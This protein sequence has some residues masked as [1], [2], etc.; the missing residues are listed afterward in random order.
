MSAPAP[1]PPSAPGAATSDAPRLRGFRMATPDV[2]A[3]MGHLRGVGWE[4]EY[5]Q[6]S[7]GRFAAALDG[8]S[9]PRV[10]VMTHRHELSFAGAG[11]IPRGTYA[12]GMLV[13]GD[14]AMSVN[15][16]SIGTDAVTIRYPYE[17]IDFKFPPAAMFVTV[18]AAANRID[19]MA[20]AVLGQQLSHVLRRGQ[21]L[22]S[23]NA[24]VVALARDLAEMPASAAWLALVDP[25]RYDQA[26]MD[27]LLQAVRLPEPIRGWSAR[28]RIVRKAEDLICSSDDPPTT[29]S[30]LCVALAVPL[31]TLEDA[32]QNCLDVS[33]KA[34]ITAM[35]L[36][37]V[38]RVLAQPGA[39]TT[40]TGA[41]TAFGFF[42]LSRFAEQ[43][44][45]LFGEK[46]SD[47]LARARR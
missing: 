21:V 5:N 3:F 40:V 10:Q 2:D 24:A 29:V 39:D 1:D 19:E 34:Y 37:R 30:E 32:F 8:V 38:R 13:K 23:H 14:G 45:R 22:P 36:N 15:H 44:T 11:H 47:T 43:Y 4:V 27:A 26:V 16:H 33:P 31:R 7:R 18:A 17:E 12:F 41:A 46:P 9:S 42:H 25:R 6:L 20:D 28:Q 35:R